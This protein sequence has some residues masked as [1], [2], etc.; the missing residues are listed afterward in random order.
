MGFG[1]LSDQGDLRASQ[2][3]TFKIF[4]EA[5]FRIDDRRFWVADVAFFNAPLGS[6]QG[7]DVT[8]GPGLVVRIG[9]LFK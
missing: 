7:N 2:Y 1:Y 3:L 8:L 4:A 5:L 9:V 6:S